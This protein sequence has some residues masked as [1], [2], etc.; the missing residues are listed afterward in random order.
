MKYLTN[1][2][3]VLLSTLL[4]SVNTF[5]QNTQLDKDIE[6]LKSLDGSQY[7]NKAISIAEKLG[8]RGEHEECLT[9]FDKA[10]DKAGRMKNPSTIAV[11]ALRKS[12]YI[13]T[14]LPANDEYIE[15]AFNSLK[16]ALSKND[17]PVVISQLSEGLLKIEPRTSNQKLVKDIRKEIDRIDSKIEKSAQKRFKKLSKDEAFELVENIK[18]SQQELQQSL[19]Q[20][21]SLFQA[22]VGRL[23]DLQDRLNKDLDTKSVVLEQMTK[24]KV[25]AQALMEYNRRLIDSMKFEAE[26]DSM[27]LFYRQVMIKEQ[28]SDLKWQESQLSL[29][30]TQRNLFLA[31][32]AIVLLT[33]LMLFMK[34]RATAKFNEELKLKNEEIAREKEESER[35]LLN[36]LPRDVAE[37]LKE[38]GKVST[39]YF[40]QVSVMFADF[41]EFSKI[42]KRLSPGELVK[43]L[44]SLF[45]SFDTIIAKC[46]IEKIKTIGDAYMCACGIPTPRRNNADKL[47]AAAV[48]IQNYVE[49]WNEKRRIKGLP[50][51]KIRIGIHTGPI[52]TGVVGKHKFAYDIWGDT[53]NIASRLESASQPGMINVSESTAGLLSK[54]YKLESRGKVEVKNM[55]PLEMYYVQG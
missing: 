19:Q 28:E 36:I 55:D 42:S 17:N 51:F 24:E 50:E 44:D 47:T 10:I 1:G 54:K 49:K 15:S 35:L 14:R 33:A 26:L 13:S 5:A 2:I 52:I 53:V 22:E 23:A 38:R 45:R 6:Q 34:W 12:D 41:V 46:E 39:Q 30:N 11:V 8:S 18:S 29:K 20:N 16:Q 9:Y 4:F 27:E 40:D 25:E 48:D 32:S 7:I 3:L 43:T 37:E 21:Q 31:L